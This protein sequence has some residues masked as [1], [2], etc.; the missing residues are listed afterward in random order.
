MNT[1]PDFYSPGSYAINGFTI[2]EDILS[3]EEILQLRHGLYTHFSANEEKS[4]ETINYA[5]ESKVAAL[6]FRKKIVKRLKQV[7][8]DKIVFTN[9]F[10]IQY[11]SFGIGGRTEGLHTDSNSEFLPENK[12]LFKPDYMFGKVGL[13]LQ[14]NT[15]EF[16]GGIDVVVGS[17]KV[18]TRFSIPI[19]NYLC[20]R[21]YLRL[22][23]INNRR[24]IKAPIKSGS[25][26]FFDSRLLHASSRPNN[27]NLTEKEIKGRAQVPSQH[28]KYAI[29]MDVCS[30]G[31][32]KE[33][34][35]NSYKRAQGEE[36]SVP[37]E[38]AFFTNNLSYSYPEDFPEYYKS[39]VDENKI[40]IPSLDQDRLRKI[41]NK[42]KIKEN[43]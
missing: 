43:I 2:I 41:K 31:S 21:L 7:L 42:L 36:S 19:L 37:T 34:I 27:L 28:C 14:D 9:N 3:Q 39:L 1:G 20:T 35:D 25:A 22:Y 13:Y 26:I 6:F 15:E 18:W 33:F 12:Y 23:K 24:K 30:L 4:Y 16:G 11:N 40:E 5:L 8:G 38:T 17:Q 32:E 29:Y 10:N